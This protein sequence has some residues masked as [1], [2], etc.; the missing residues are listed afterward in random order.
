MS[1][2]EKAIEAIKVELEN[3]DSDIEIKSA[4][5]KELKAVRRKLASTIGA[6]EK[7]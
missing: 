6:L 4:E 7:L 2:N 5:I 1:A 3:I